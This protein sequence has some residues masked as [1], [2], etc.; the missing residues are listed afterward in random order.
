M[1]KTSIHRS[2]SKMKHLAIYKQGAYTYLFKTEIPDCF[3]AIGKYVFGQSILLM[4]ISNI[5]NIEFLFLT[6]TSKSSS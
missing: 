2:Q 5:T 3:V 6:L 4:K 1:V